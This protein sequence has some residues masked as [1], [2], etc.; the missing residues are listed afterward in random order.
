MPRPPETKLRRFLMQG[1]MWVIL[2]ATIGVAALVDRHKAAKLEVKLGDPVK[3]E[4]GISIRLPA[5]WK[6]METPDASETLIA[7]EDTAFDRAISVQLDQLSISDLFVS[8]GRGTLQEQIPMGDGS[9]T[10]S[11][12]LF[13]EQGV[14]RY[15]ARRVLPRGRVLTITL[16][17]SAM[18]PPQQLKAEKDL[19]KQIAASVKVEGDSSQSTPASKPAEEVGQE[20]LPV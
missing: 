15:M 12:Q 6:E 1:I 18:L 19:I 2:G 7:V 9:G 5:G 17:T 8:R 16:H 3:L 11:R 10:L 13:E 4:G 14:L 20:Q